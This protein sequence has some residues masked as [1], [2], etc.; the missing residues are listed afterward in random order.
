MEVPGS[1]RGGQEVGDLP[2]RRRPGGRGVR[3]RRQGRLVP[4]VP[5]VRHSVRSDTGPVREEIDLVRLTM[6]Y[7]QITSDIRRN[8]PG[9]VGQGTCHGSPT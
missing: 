3:Y 2:V 6:G 9:G 8:S 7:R 5:D 1:F 4:K